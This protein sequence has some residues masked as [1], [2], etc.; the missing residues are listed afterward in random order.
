MQKYEVDVDPEVLGLLDSASKK[1]VLV[2][3]L[4]T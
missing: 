3:L 1:H 4:M 2:L